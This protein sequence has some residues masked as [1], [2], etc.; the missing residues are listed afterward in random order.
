MAAAHRDSERIARV[1]DALTANGADALLVSLPRHV[2]LLTGYYPVVGTSIAI[3]TREGQV[4]L[5]APEDE[6]EFSQAGWAD[7]AEYFH[8]AR[9]DQ[10][11]PLRISATDSLRRLAKSMQLTPRVLA[12]ESGPDSEPASYSAMNLYGSALASIAEGS[13]K[14]IALQDGSDMLARLC[15]VKTPLELGHIRVACSIAASAFES[16]RLTIQPS[17]S[18]IEIASH[19]S[20]QFAAAATSAAIDRQHAFFY[21]MSGPN[22]AKASYAYAHSRSRKVARN[23]CVLVHC[24]SQVYG[25][26]TDITRT[27]LVGS[28]GAEHSAALHAVLEAR[29]AAL[30]AVKPGAKASDVDRAAREVL[31]RNGFGADFKHGAGHGVGFRAISAHARPRVHPKS[32]DLL[33]TGMVFNLEPAIYRDGLNGIRQCEMVAVTSSGAELL[34][35]FH[36]RPEALQI[37]LPQAI[38]SRRKKAS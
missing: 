27:Y 9:L 17:L 23:D 26:W 20:V 11:T 32:D 38:A 37:D 19:F 16:G 2:F 12:I 35:P 10:L 28:A 30:G 1:Q 5:L 33:E 8:P 36:S 24:N 22:S 7:H 29:D 31:E 3:C 14:G 4:G 15:S 21:C 25:Y 18:E 6:Q 34:T 13:W